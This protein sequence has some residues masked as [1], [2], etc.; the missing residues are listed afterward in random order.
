M[1]KALQI[2][3]SPNY[4]ITDTGDIYSR[5][6]K[7][8]RIKKLKPAKDHKGYLRVGLSNHGT[9]K[10]YK[11][12]RLVAEAFI[13]NPENKPQV[14]H[15]NGIKDDNRVENLE[16]ATQSE[17]IQHA[18]TVLGNKSPN[19][20]KFGKDNHSS[21]AVL[22]IRNG[23]IISEFGSIKEATRM[24]GI[25]DTNIINCCKG[26]YKQSHGYQWRY[27]NESN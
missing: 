21:K 17:N 1:S 7:L 20:R 25:P 22:Q 14:N 26:R 19:F 6:G 15:K 8:G 3:V 18:Y 2:K 4:Y 16:W 23:I 10:T 24:T 5:K 11:L 27:K 12:H 13:P 9:N